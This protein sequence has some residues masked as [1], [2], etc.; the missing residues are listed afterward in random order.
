M[1]EAEPN[2]ANAR[3]VPLYRDVF[4][5][6]LLA[7]VLAWPAIIRDGAFYF[8]DAASYVKGGGA[9]F[10]ILGAVGKTVLPDSAATETVDQARAAEVIDDVT[11]E[12]VGLRSVTYSVFAYTMYVGSE[13]LLTLAFAQALLMAVLAMIFLRAALGAV[14]HGEMIGVIALLGA[15]TSAPWYTS[16]AMPDIFGAAAILGVILLTGYERRLNTVQRVYVLALVAFA[17]SAHTSNM[18]LA[19]P[20]TLA[21]VF[22]LWRRSRAGEEMAAWRPYAWL[23]APLALGLVVTMAIGAI[24]FGEPSAVPKRYPF[25]LARSVADGPARWHLEEHCDEYQ[26]AV[27]EVF[28]EIPETV[29][30]FLW[31]PE[32]LRH[33]STPEQMERIRAEESLIVQRALAEYPYTQVLKSAE[34]GV[35]QLFLFGIAKLETGLTMASDERGRPVRARS[36]RIQPEVVRVFE[37]VEYAVVVMAAIG[38]AWM[39]LRAG[40]SGREKRAIRLLLVGLVANAVICGVI[41]APV[42]RYQGRVIWLLPLMFTVL[43]LTRRRARFPES[44]IR[45][46]PLE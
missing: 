37:W 6:F 34:N 22:E 41:S 15:A 38:I 40:F 35:K 19:I 14:S 11:E 5:T 46:T 45:H 2:A 42:H 32:G 9:V 16:F 24:G 28:D 43:A 12:V 17:V 1:S 27:C 39:G 3:S 36:T 18:L 25:V 8:P 29:Q 13:S 31:G 23:T 26:Y 33:N 21:G 44:S 10:R 7:I 30:D 4:Y 20:M